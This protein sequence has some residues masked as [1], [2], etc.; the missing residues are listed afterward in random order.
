MT[1]LV[2]REAQVV[3]SSVKVTSEGKARADRLSAEGKCLGCGEPIQADDQVRCGQCSTCYQRTLIAIGKGKIDRKT[4]IRQ[5]KMLP[6]T[7][8]G[9]KPKNA[10]TRELSE[11]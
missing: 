7:K 9:R 8:G 2:I 10:Y 3:M 6:A 11:L 4:L 5:G 1:E